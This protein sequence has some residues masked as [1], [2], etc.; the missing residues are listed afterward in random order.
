MEEIEQHK[1]AVQEQ[2]HRHDYYT[3]IFV[4]EAEGV[5]HI[6]F[7]DY[8]LTTNT[9]Y[10]LSPE[11]VHHMEVVGLPKGQVL[12]FTADFLQYYSMPI[13]Q[14]INLDLFYNCAEAPP[15]QVPQAKLAAVNNVLK[16]IAVEDDHKEWNY[17]QIIGA[18]IKHLFYLLKRIKTETKP[19]QSFIPSRKSIIVQQFKR[20]LEQSFRSNHKVS[21]YAA[22]QTLSSIYLNEVIKAETGSSAKEMIQQRI[23]LEAKR[24]AKYTDWSMKEIAYHL[25]FEDNAHFSKLFKKLEGINFSTFKNA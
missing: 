25:G 8:P 18:Q 2:P 22:L 9:F 20:D 3:L 21:E 10:L 1:P 14:L 7:K 5:H 17:L 15:I 12:L 16:I 19:A 24:L 11:Q 23:L 4:S 6:D 13:E